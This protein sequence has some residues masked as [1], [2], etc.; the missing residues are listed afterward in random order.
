MKT[1]LLVAGGIVALLAGAYLLAGG[2]VG[3]GGGGG[4]G[5]ETLG[6]ETGGPAP[7]TGGGGGDGGYPQSIFQIPPLPDIPN[8]FGGGTTTTTTKKD[9][10]VANS[11]PMF[12]AGS[13][14]T[15]VYYDASGKFLGIP[16]SEPMFG[17][18][19]TGTGRSN[20]G[21]GFFDPLIRLLD[22]AILGVPYVSPYAGSSTG[23]VTAPNTG[24]GLFDPLSRLF[25]NA[26]GGQPYWGGS[27]SPAVPPAVLGPTPDVPAPKKVEYVNPSAGWLDV[28]G[29]SINPA[30]ENARYI[31]SL[32]PAWQASKDNPLAAQTYTA[33]GG[34]TST[35]GAGVY[36][37][38]TTVGTS[39]QLD[40]GEQA[41]TAAK[42]EA[43]GW[44][45]PAVGGTT[46][47]AGSKKG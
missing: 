7:N 31:K 3:G 4:V 29:P 11:E 39:R 16:N 41:S 26:V 9:D 19:S 43:R 18:G 44:S 27:P 30:L 20:T 14:G 36:S 38:G 28:T 1:D 45:I 10:T 32:G 35:A 33:T 47:I 40:A 6:Q 8:L 13:T 34:I 15:G 23:N 2:K 25:N 17:V 5:A 22:N 46:T 21:T 24:T 42:Y 37:I 12:G